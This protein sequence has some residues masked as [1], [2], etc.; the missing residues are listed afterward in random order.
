M[1]DPLDVSLRVRMRYEA[2]G[3]ALRAIGDIEGLR[4]KAT[5]LGAVDA[6]ERLGRGLRSV[7][8]PAQAAT[9]EINALGTATARFGTIGTFGRVERDV[10]RLAGSLR[11]GREEALGLGRAIE[12]VGTTRSLSTLERDIERV[13]RRAD[14]TSR[15]LTAVGS[16]SLVAASSARHAFGN[17]ALSAA[18]LGGAAR[19]GMGGAAAGGLAAGAGIAAVGIG[20]AKATREAVTFETA[21]A[22][23]K[24][25]VD[26]LSP[27]GLA[28]MERTIL[29][30]SRTTGIAKEEMAKLVAQAGFA[31]RPTEELARFAEFGAK[32]A[33]AFGMTAEDT[34][35]KLA[36]LGNV[37]K[38]NQ[39]GIEDLADGINVLGDSTAAKERQIIDF[40][41]RTGETGKALKF[42]ALQTAAIGAAAI[43]TGKEAEVAATGFNAF[44]MKLGTADRQNEDF[45]KGLG[46]I[47]LSARRL[48]AEMA[49]NPVEGFLNVLE[50]LNKLPEEKK[51]DIASR[52]GG[53][54]YGD[55][56]L[57]YAGAID[58][59]RKA[60]GRMEDQASRSGSV[61]KT[62]RIVN[63]TTGS[64]LARAGASIE[65]FGTKLGQR[66]TPAVS[67]AA[68]AVERWFGGMTKALELAERAEVIGGKLAKGL[69][70]DPKEAAELGA[71]PRLKREADR[72][73]DRERESTERRAIVESEG[74]ERAAREKASPTAKPA[75]APERPREPDEQDRVAAEARERTRQKLQGE[76]GT[77]QSEIETRMGGGFETTADRLRLRRLRKQYERQF[78]AEDPAGKTGP[79][80]PDVPGT[81]KRSDLADGARV[82]LAAYHDEVEQSLGRT[83]RLV[84]E[85]T[86]RMREDLAI[87][88]RF[89]L[90]AGSFGN[91]ARLQNAAFGG[92]SR[93]GGTGGS[94]ADRFSGGAGVAGTRVGPGRF[95]LAVP[96]TR[97]SGSDAAPAQR[98]NLRYGR[99]DNGPG[100]ARAAPS[101]SSG[102]GEIP[103]SMM[104]R[105]RELYG[106]LRQEGFNH[107]QSSAILG[108][109][110][111]ESDIG[112]KSNPREGADGIIH[113]RLDRLQKLRAFAAARG[114][115]GNGSLKTQAAFLRHEM[116][117]D[118]LER[119][120]SEAFRRS[121]GVAE[122]SAALKPY[123]RYG[124][125]STATR[126]QNALRY[127]RAFKDGVGPEPAAAGTGEKHDPLGGAGRR[128]SSGFGMRE[129]PI[130]GGR[131]MHWGQDMAAPAGTDV[132]AM[133]GGRVTSI[134]RHGDVTV[135]HPDGSTKTYR[136][137]DA[138]GL[139]KGQQVEGGQ[140][141]GA[142]RAHDPRSTG[143]HLHLEATDAQGRR[144][145]PMADV[146]AASKA[147][148][149]REEAYRSR[150]NPFG[151]AD[152]RL[153][154][155]PP[156]DEA[157]T[158]RAQR[159]LPEPD[160][161][162]ARSPRFE[163]PGMLQVNARGAAER[164][165][166]SARESAAPHRPAVQNFYGG[167][168]EQATARRAVLE[169][170]REVRRSQARALHDIGRVA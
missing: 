150:A 49:A 62:F 141:I 142:L 75:P 90:D 92:A 131:R 98:N 114:E 30:T 91:G 82:S 71:N 94:A 165:G 41:Y 36:K 33:G 133:E 101:G 87:K 105:A 102:G 38:L 106:A 167:F 13:G 110:E 54:E 88:A 128:Y 4:A 61:E 115:K 117:T 3:E 168:D 154:A 18:G 86:R 146:E 43:S 55:D 155:A 57:A 120:K 96:S 80:A 103:A 66:F 132:N 134:S 9:R 8:A 139:K 70:L 121:E 46:S 158:E 51:L 53:L 113:W 17:E 19:L 77:L 56:L 16:A 163:E 93:Y 11:H 138:S 166:G 124:D 67:A 89:D 31:G 126:T 125:N 151:R 59:I 10:V 48:K 5:Q 73:A 58:D 122:A 109:A 76:I 15:K 45:K 39:A 60:L 44:A 37:Y 27:E 28:A 26:N 22:E 143:P 64:D 63:A 123:I 84:R 147:R 83:E 164:A 69:P 47:G 104:G 95:G 12:R 153:G 7:T 32:T 35:D 145:D 68:L 50:R 119:R 72:I 1:A 81:G 157:A 6:G 162:K 42:T 161:P 34:G 144:I 140:R 170:N 21:M 65:A 136:H 40:L 107:A 100:S 24:K 74:R 127:D 78:G 85:T 112:V 14:E 111:R 118:P 135:T 159:R 129:H 79:A 152:Q 156:P 97:Q 25:A 169:Q 23:V 116:T 160:D 52:L 149:T 137:I 99:T 148:R 20:I 108:H 29:R 2:R 130:H